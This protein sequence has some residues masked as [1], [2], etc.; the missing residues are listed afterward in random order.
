VSLHHI[1]TQKEGV[2]ASI[3][4]IAC[5]DV[6]GGDLYQDT[7]RKDNTCSHVMLLLT[8]TIREQ[9]II[10]TVLRNMM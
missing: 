6:G 1:C 9:S 10:C 3:S 8:L 2:S 4:Y 7:Y 5:E